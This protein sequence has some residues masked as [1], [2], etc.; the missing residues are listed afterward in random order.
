M[1]PF[2]LIFLALGLAACTLEP[3]SS[4]AEIELTVVVNT[5][6]T[7]EATFTAQPEASPTTTTSPL[8]QPSPENRSGDNNCRPR[9]DLP[10][11]TVVTGDSLSSIAIRTNSS[12]PQ[13]VEWNCLANAN[14]IVVGM[15]LQVAREALPA[16]LTPTFTPTPLPTNTQASIQ[17]SN[18]TTLGPF[19]ALALAPAIEAG[20][21]SNWTDFLIAPQTTI[22]IHW[23][24]IDP[25][26]YTDV[27]QIE[28]FYT[29]DTGTRLSLGIDADKSDGMTIS[30]TAPANVSGSLMAIARYQQNR[31]IISP[32]I[33]VRDK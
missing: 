8:P 27:G 5:P 9:S 19:G 18:S 25:Q 1:R 26:Y 17:G 24:G 11:Y 4:I 2:I 3:A 31:S 15:R 23:S 13:L 12:V 33:H 10:S 7:E 30:W 16:T 20:N 22:T 14:M 32:A 21:P 28:F 6:V 29:S